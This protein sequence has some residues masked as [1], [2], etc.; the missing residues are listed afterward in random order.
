[1]HFGCAH[2]KNFLPREK[3]KPSEQSVR[4]SFYLIS[5]SILVAA[6]HGNFLSR[7]TP[8][9]NIRPPRQAKR[10]VIHFYRLFLV[11]SAQHV[12]WSRSY[13]PIFYLTVHT[14]FAH[15]A[16]QEKRPPAY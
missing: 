3:K 5:Q 12:M 16:R 2:H 8:L 10:M 1:M 9:S 15:G 7:K 14:L 13:T 11:D 4:Y 6:T